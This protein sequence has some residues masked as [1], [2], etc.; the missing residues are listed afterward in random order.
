MN[1]PYPSIAPLRMLATSVLQPAQRGGRQCHS[2]TWGPV[3]HSTLTSTMPAEHLRLNYYNVAQS[4]THPLAWPGCGPQ[5]IPPS[6]CP[7]PP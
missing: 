4:G 5:Q 6:H 3:T 2:P 1:L 7:V